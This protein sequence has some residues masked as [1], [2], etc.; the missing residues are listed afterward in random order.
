MA[1]AQTDDT[2]LL[3]L[4]SSDGFPFQ[5]VLQE[6]QSTIALDG[7][8]WALDEVP[9]SRRLVRLYADSFNS[10][11]PPLAVIQHAQ[12]A[13]RKFVLISA[14]GTHIV[15]KLR[16]ADHLRQL[17]IE[18]GGPDNDVIKAFFS[19][20]T[21]T[22]ASATALVLATSQAVQ[23]AQV[24]EW[25]TRAFFL[26]GGEPRLFYP[27]MGMA[28]DFAKN[29]TFHPHLASTPA[30]QQPQ[31]PFGAH[32]MHPFGA[33]APGAAAAAAAAA[34]A[35]PEMHYS[36]KHNGLYLY[37]SRLVRPVWH[38][39]LVVPGPKDCPL[40]STVDVEEIDWIM[41]KLNDLAAFLEKNSATATA[42]SMNMTSAAHMDPQV[43]N[44]FI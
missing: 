28:S 22:Q 24:A 4:L 1:S 33:G 19:W 39:S 13:A 35:M 23:D 8:V 15:S 21:E 6:G 18:H 42:S 16:P 30:Q 38:A 43:I 7:R 17:L 26:Y 44:S 40:A 3:W 14:T 25:A 11:Q 12:A 10:M 34:G 27:G 5:N 32:Q 9:A 37:F 41:T 31:S 2:D 20:H 29:V 36:F